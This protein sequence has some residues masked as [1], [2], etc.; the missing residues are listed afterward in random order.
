MRQEHMQELEWEVDEDYNFKIKLNDK[1]KDIS[2]MYNA[3]LD[4][5][6]KAILI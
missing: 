4:E 3:I 1:V 2:D 5:N 6:W